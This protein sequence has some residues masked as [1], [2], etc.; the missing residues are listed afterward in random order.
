M[1]RLARS[2]G[3]EVVL[4]GTPE[5]GFLLSPPDFYAEIAKEFR[6][7]YEGEVLGKILRDSSLKADQIHPN[8]AGYRLMAQRVYE[9]LRKSGAL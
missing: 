9:L 1:I 8:A 3:V 2:R 5:F 7:P 6:V 4:I